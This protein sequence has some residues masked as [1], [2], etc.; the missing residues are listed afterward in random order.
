MKVSEIFYSAQGEGNRTGVLSAWIR[1]A[2]C[3]LRCPGFFQNNPTDPSTYKNPL[4]NINPKTIQVLEDLLP[5]KYGCDTI[6]AIDPRFKHLF[7]DMSVSEVVE[8]IKDLLPNQSWIHPVTKNE[9]D[10]A[11]TGGEPML[12]QEEIVE[13]VNELQPPTVQIETNATKFANKTFLEW[14]QN[15]AV[16]LN[17]NISPKLYNVSGEKN[18]VNIDVIEQY[19]SLYPIGCLKFVINDSDAAWEEL[20]NVVEQIRLRDI[21]FPI[22]VMPVGST[23]EQQ[24]N[25]NVLSKIATKAVQNGFHL[26]SRLQSIFWGNAVGV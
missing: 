19:Y 22:Y 16:S 10:L 21:N 14:V 15:Y 11:F 13:I 8:I 9:I 6:Y 7:I 2:G 26:S 5:V 18:A 17:W 24:T 3:N 4:E 1:F 25:V 12:H 20:L 23:Y